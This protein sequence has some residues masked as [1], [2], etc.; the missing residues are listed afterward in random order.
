[1]TSEPTPLVT[2]L[3]CDREA[4]A[5]L[6][7]SGR[8]SMAW[9]MYVE[10]RCDA[11]FDVQMFARHRLAA[12]EEVRLATVAAREKYQEPTDWDYGALDACHRV[13]TAIGTLARNALSPTTTE[14]QR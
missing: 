7:G 11:Q 3:P 1:M 12:L 5:R 9:R 10:G 2:V 6:D 14:D 4:A 13:E 8:G